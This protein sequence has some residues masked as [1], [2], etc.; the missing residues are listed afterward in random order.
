MTTIARDR[1]TQARHSGPVAPTVP[2]SARPAL[3]EIARCA[4]GVAV[5]RAKPEELGTLVDQGIGTM[6]R[7]AAFVTLS[8]DGELRGCVGTLDADRRIEEAIARATISAASC[9]PRFRP[10]EAHELPFLR[11]DISVLGAPV[12]LGDVADFDRGVHG[13][14][15]E[16]GGRSALLLP[17]VASDRGWGGEAMLAAACGKAGLPLDAWHNPRTRR[18][19]FATLRFGGPAVQDVPSPR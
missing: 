18:R 3:L 15:V 19:I 2:K 4:L 14:I 17:E 12:A 13:V 5:G 10:I 8:E 9:D 16:L 7:A 1:A 6:I 11:V